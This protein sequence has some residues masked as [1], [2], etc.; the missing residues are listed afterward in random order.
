MQVKRE[1]G[2]E[3]LNKFLLKDNEDYWGLYKML[4]AIDKR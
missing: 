2:L 1:E 3:A 4:N